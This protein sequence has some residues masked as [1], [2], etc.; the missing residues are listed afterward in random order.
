MSNAWTFAKIN[1]ILIYLTNDIVI[2]ALCGEY[3][4]EILN[5]YVICTIWMIVCIIEY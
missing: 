4:L 5:R 2:P 1:E 3:V